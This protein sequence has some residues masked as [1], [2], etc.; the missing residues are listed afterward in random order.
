MLFTVEKLSVLG[1]PKIPVP[2]HQ[3]AQLLAETEDAMYRLYTEKHTQI[4]SKIRILERTL[5]QQGAWTHIP[6]T[7][8]VGEYFATFLD[9]MTHNFGEHARGYQQIA[10]TEHR[11]ARHRQILGALLHYTHDR[12]AWD[13][14]LDM[15]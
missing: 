15:T 6:K 13:A 1:Y 11:A 5:A 3:I 9:S 10:S 2:E 8:V 12:A 4:L 7:H 14:A